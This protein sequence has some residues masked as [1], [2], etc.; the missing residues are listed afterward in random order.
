MDGSLMSA[1]SIRHSE[2]SDIE[3][4]RQIFAEPSNYASTLQLPHPSHQQWEKY[5]STHAEG[6]F[7]LVACQA[8]TILGQLGLDVS[9]RPRRRHVATLGMA[10]KTTARRQG[11]GSALLSAGI[12]LAERW[13]AV[14]RIEIQVYVDNEAAIA[15]YRK[16]NFCIEGTYKQ[17][18]FR[19]GA[20]VDAYAMARLGN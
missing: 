5:F 2:T 20:F 19:D 8:D 14:R 12:E 4:I 15:L 13:C 6:R 11:V 16:F 7:S 1:V 18:A 17:Y 9:Q 3:Q 10:V